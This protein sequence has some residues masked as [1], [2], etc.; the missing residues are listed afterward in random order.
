MYGSSLTLER[1]SL[2]VRAGTRVFSLPYSFLNNIELLV[3]EA[4]EEE[5]EDPFLFFLA[6]TCAEEVD[7]FD[8]SSVVK[9]LSIIEESLRFRLALGFN[10]SKL[11][12]SENEEDDG[13]A[14]IKPADEGGEGSGSD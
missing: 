14:V 2:S 10:R 3:G 8:S 4:E 11:E 9:L 5:E 1:S 6:P 13:D 7:G 12:R